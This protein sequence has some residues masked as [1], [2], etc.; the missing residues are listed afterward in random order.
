MFTSHKSDK[1]CGVIP[2]LDLSGEQL[3]EDRVAE[4]SMREYIETTDKEMDLWLSIHPPA[5]RAPTQSP[6]QSLKVH[7]TYLD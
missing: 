3:G 7:C 1:K 6:P 2:P 5:T 4:L